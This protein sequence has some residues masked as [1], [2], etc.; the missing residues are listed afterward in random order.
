VSSRTLSL[1]ISR[2]IEEKERISKESKVRGKMYS[3]TS[4]KGGV[5]ATSVA[6]NV[7]TELAKL[8]STRVALMDMNSPIG[9]AASYL[10][11]KP[12]FSVA[13]ALAAAPRLDSTLLETFMTSGWGISVLPGSK[14]LRAGPSPLPPSLAKLLRVISQTYTHTLIDLPASMDQ[15]LFKTVADS[16]EALLVIMTPELPAL[17]RTHRLIMTLAGYGCADRVRLILNRD[18]SRGEIDEREIKR[19]LSHPIFWR[20]PNNYGSAIQAVNRGRPLVWAN[21]S[22]LSTSYRRLTQTLSGL[23]VPKRRRGILRLFS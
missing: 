23:D 5:G 22:G 2:Y 17:W 7:A 18:N 9:D 4:A 20:L 16:S 21:H 8:R 3:V 19:A 13:D 6:V 10:D 14:Q 12:R 15:E 11:L 1:A